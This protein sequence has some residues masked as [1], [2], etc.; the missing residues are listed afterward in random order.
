MDDDDKY[1][2]YEGVWS[3][4]QSGRFWQR[5]N[6]IAGFWLPNSIRFKFFSV[7]SLFHLEPRLD[8]FEHL[9]RDDR[10]PDWFAQL[11]KSA[12]FDVQ[13]GLGA[14]RY[15]LSNIESLEAKLIDACDILRPVN[16]NADVNNGSSG[17]GATQK[18]DY[19][20]AAYHLATYRTLEYASL[21]VSAFYKHRVSNF[22]DL[23]PVL[24]RSKIEG[25]DAMAGLVE[26]VL[27]LEFAAIKL[28][29][30]AGKS[31]RNDI[32]HYEPVSAGCL[33]VSYSAYSGFSARI[34]G[35]GHD[36]EIASRGT[37]S[38]ALTKV[39]H[40]WQESVEVGIFRLFEGLNIYYPEQFTPA[41][42]AFLDSK[43]RLD[44]RDYG[45]IDFTEPEPEAQQQP[46]TNR[47]LD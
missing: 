39:L 8:V 5:V 41:Y 24:R 32:S 46:A 13:E 14:S 43:P 36:L 6:E 28:K 16:P 33:S 38:D 35:G 44:P 25:S 2:E 31:L 26:D 1:L 3:D 12:C 17:G 18:L 45:S 27:K 4:E 22:A 15:H 34:V 10:K 7:Q 29:D 19:E 47:T 21:A 9:R 30:Q 42:C 20:F 23:L 37:R 40:S 11:K